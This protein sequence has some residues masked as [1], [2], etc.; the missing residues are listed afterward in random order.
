MEQ[1]STLTTIV[2][3]PRSRI[4]KTAKDHKSGAW[5]KR[6]ENQAL[7]AAWQHGDEKR[8]P[9]GTCDGHRNKQKAGKV[10]K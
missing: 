7:R 4:G 2:P 9:Y 3:H 6:F 8:F 10:V 1:Q 5:A